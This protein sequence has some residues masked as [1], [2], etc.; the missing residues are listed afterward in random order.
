[1]ELSFTET[2]NQNST[3]TSTA[4]SSTRLPFYCPSEPDFMWNFHDTTFSWILAAIV[5]TA[6]P[7]TVVLNAV[8]IIAVKQRRELQKYS[9]IVLSSMAVADLLVGAV[10][11]PIS[12]T[13][14]L[15]IMHQVYL[16]GVCTLYTVNIALMGC[17]LFSSLFHLI[18][19]AWERYIAITKWIDYRVIV[20]SSRLKKLAI[21]AWLAAII[22][23]LPLVV[24]LGIGVP[25]EVQSIWYIMASLCIALSVVVFVCLYVMV[26]T[27]LRKRRTNTTVQVTA[28]VQTKLETKVA[29]TTGLLTAAV[30]FTLILGGALTV[31]GDILPA[32]R[33]KSTFRIADTLLQLNS[34]INP[35]IYCYR[36]RRFRKAVLELLRIKKPQ[37]PQ[38]TRDGA[39]RF[40]RQKD[41]FGSVEDVQLQP[42]KSVEKRTRLTRSTSCDGTMG[43]P[44]NYQHCSR[45]MMLK[46]AVSLPS[47]VKNSRI[48]DSSPLRAPSSVVVT[49]ATIYTESDPRHP[50]RI[51][52]SE[53][54]YNYINTGNVDAK[55]HKSLR[56]KFWA[57]NA[58]GKDENSS[59]YVENNAAVVRPKSTPC[60]SMNVN[61]VN[62]S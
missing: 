54:C 47:L 34:M 55:V 62:E 22:I 57:T 26:Y 61:S 32:L 50:A 21:V 46:R 16:E 29:K 20:T 42:P 8:V 2:M 14:D 24:M 41:R 17:F 15:L 37:E 11:M 28:L 52:Y 27:G 44:E 58:S 36:D 4:N 38:A 43:F 60:F 18:V 33:E 12:T 30:I 7:I 6:S 13:V 48:V 10:S 5:M 3:E 51:T 59:E 53:S 23:L 25:F 45:E 9:N 40:L 49:L 1:M 39:T 56:S 31:L 19:V 35:L